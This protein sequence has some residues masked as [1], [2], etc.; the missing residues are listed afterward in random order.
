[1]SLSC[2]ALV[3]LVLLALPLP[4]FAQAPAQ[5]VLRAGTEIRLETTSELSSKSQVKGD[6]VKLRTIEDVRIGDAVVIAKGTLAIAQVVDARAKGALGMSGRLSVQPIYIVVGSQ[7]VRLGGQASD[8]GS[9][10]AGAVVG[11]VVLTPGFTG[12]SAKIPEGTR[13][14]GYVE[15]AVEFPVESLR[16]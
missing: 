9:I 14:T 10:A 2:R 13:L 6:L 7:T 4:A 15:H 11:M 8:K 3:R 16:P 5:I 12:R 1:M